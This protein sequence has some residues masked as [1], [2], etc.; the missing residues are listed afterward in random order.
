MCAGHRARC[1]LV[2]NLRSADDRRKRQRTGDPFTAADEVRNDAIVFEAPEFAGS[3]ESSDATLIFAGWA[4][5]QQTPVDA[6]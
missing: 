3:A 4:A 2:H 5:G 6:V 1:K